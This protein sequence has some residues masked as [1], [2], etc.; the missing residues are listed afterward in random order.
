M[1]V[2]P[3]YDS[4]L[5]LG[6]ERSNGILLDVGACRELLANMSVKVRVLTLRNAPVGVDARK[7]AT[8]GYPLR[9][10]VTAD[11]HQGDH[12]S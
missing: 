10:I 3:A 11:L 1:A 7:A 6:Q 2:L 5:R 12:Q 4:V 8:D 9:N